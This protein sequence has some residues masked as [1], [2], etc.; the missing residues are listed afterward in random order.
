[1]NIL[2]I[3]DSHDAIPQLEHVLKRAREEFSVDAIIHCGDMVKPSTLDVFQDSDVPLYYVMGNN[4][5]DFDE[6][7]RACEQRGIYVRVDVG[8]VEL[9]GRNIAFTHYPHI[10]DKLVHFGEYDLVCYGHRHRHSCEK[11]E[12]TWFLNPG[13]LVGRYG[14][15]HFAV[16]NTKKNTPHLYPLEYHKKH[17]HFE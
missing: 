13:D 10:A 3:S 17:F 14:D 2:I 9:D 5:D 1:M 16:Y 15:P 4:E 6:M 8:E 11:V 12:K 7:Q